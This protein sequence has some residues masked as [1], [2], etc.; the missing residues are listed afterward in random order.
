MPLVRTRTKWFYSIASPSLSWEQ[1]NKKALLLP[2]EDSKAY[3]SPHCRAQA[4]QVGG[5]Q[6]A[7]REEMAGGLNIGKQRDPGQFLCPMA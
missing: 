3:V 4:R 1:S 5:R 7:W 2:P 6:K